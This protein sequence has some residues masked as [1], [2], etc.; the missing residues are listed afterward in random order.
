MN[1]KPITPPGLVEQLQEQLSDA[2]RQLENPKLYQ[3]ARVQLEARAKLLRWEIG[4]L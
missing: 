4:D 1:A 2:L 3:L